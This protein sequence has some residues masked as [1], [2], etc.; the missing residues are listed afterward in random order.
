MVTLLGYL[1]GLTAAVIIITAVVFGSLSFFHARKLG[2]KLLYYAGALVVVVGLLWLGPFV[3][4]LTVLLTGGNIPGELYG[5]LSYIW[6]GPAVV[7]AF[8]LGGELMAPEKTKIIVGIY[9]V[10]GVIFEVF[11]FIF[12]NG[13]NSA[14]GTFTWDDPTAGNLLNT[15]F[16]RASPT[17][18]LVALFLISV[19]IFLGIGFA[20]KAKQATGDLR[21]KFSYLSIA[22]IIFVV[23]GALDSI[24]D[25]GVA[26]GFVRL[27]MA[28][29]AIWTYLGLKT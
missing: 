16:N 25:P 27:L 9:T 29:F 3:E 18:W 19:L 10:L 12:P 1:D 2:A 13:N 26:I 11:M 8:Y 4:F 17:F 20:L 21:R 7:I 5:I 28:T 22:F 24:L 14:I 6:V 15:G 23:S